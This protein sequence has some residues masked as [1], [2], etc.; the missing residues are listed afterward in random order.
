MSGS[1]S[2]GASAKISSLPALGLIYVQ[3]RPVAGG[4]RAL[5]AKLLVDSRE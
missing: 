4:V 2:A 1:G 3:G 5:L